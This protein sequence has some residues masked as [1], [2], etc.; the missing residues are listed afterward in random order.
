MTIIDPFISFNIATVLLLVGKIL[1]LRVEVLRRYSIPEAVAGGFLCVAVVGGIWVSSGHRVSFNLELRDYL[2]LVFFSG[3]GL[4]SDVRTLLKGGRSMFIL[5]LL[6][7]VFITVQNSAGMALA[8]L[9]G[10]DPKAGLIVGSI[11]LTGGVGTTLAWA[12][13]FAESHGITNALELGIATNTVGM[14]SACMIGGPISAYLIKRRNIRGSGIADLDLGASNDGRHRRINYFCVLWALLALNVTIMFGT[15]LH[16]L[17]AQ[18]GLTLPAFVSS[19]IAG[20]VLRNL[21]PVAPSKLVRRVWPGTD[22][23]LGLISDLALGL[24]MIMALMSL[25]LWELA[26]YF[27]FIIVVLAV[28]IFLTIAFTVMVIFPAM[29][30][31]YEAAVISAGFSGISLGSTATAIANMT[32]VAQQHGAAHKAFVIVP[33]VCGF[34][35]DIVNALIIS[36]FLH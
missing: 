31:D 8:Q 2:L 22:D 18:T 1:T 14:I 20:I 17:I 29:G 36:A 15:A 10:L 35:I 23:A 32:A 12:P 33:L 7:S 25:Q 6:A 5:I 21:L 13:I 9:F 27:D 11:S 16:G 24:F 34:F 3:I 26:S 4:K 30:R 19:L 28:Q